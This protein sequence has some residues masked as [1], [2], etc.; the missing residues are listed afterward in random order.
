LRRGGQR[1]HY[2]RGSSSGRRATDGRLSVEDSRSGDFAARNL[3]DYR[4]ILQY[5]GYAG[6]RKLA[7]DS[8]ANGLRL[9]ECWAHLRSRFFDLHANGESAVASATVEQMKLL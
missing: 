5:D 2:R 4:C 8:R 7:S 1:A 9:A 6:Y 3:G